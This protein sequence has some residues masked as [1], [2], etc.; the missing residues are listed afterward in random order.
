MDEWKN[1]GTSEARVVGG[2]TEQHASQSLKVV[3][4]LSFM[5][6]V[7][8]QFYLF[9]DIFFLNTIHTVWAT[10]ISLVGTATRYR[11]DGWGVQKTV[12]ARFSVPFETG[13]RARPASYKRGSGCFCPRGESAR[14]GSACMA[15]NRAKFI[16]TEC[17]AI[18]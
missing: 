2:V 9:N 16:T 6:K 15:C 11:L 14:A 8:F 13:A 5:S 18:S 12:G 7:V 4:L 10:G 1:V 17:S 3:V